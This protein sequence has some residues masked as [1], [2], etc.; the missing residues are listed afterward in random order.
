MKWS[1]S[2][3][4]LLQVRGG[5]ET[6]RPRAS[7]HRE[8]RGTVTGAVCISGKMRRTVCATRKGSS[9]RTAISGGALCAVR[10]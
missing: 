4:A 3:K 6:L 5:R 7:S 8:T 9:Y 2:S 10:G 1:C